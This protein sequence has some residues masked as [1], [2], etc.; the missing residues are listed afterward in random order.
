MVL[1]AP[2]ELVADDVPRPD[3]LAAGARPRDPQRHLRHGLQDLQRRD[4]GQL[5]AHHGPRDGRRGRRRR[6][7]RR[8]PRAATRVIVDPELY[9]GACFHCRI[10]QTHLCPNG[11]LIGR[12]TNGGFA[13]YVA[14][15]ASHVFR[16]ARLDRQPRPRR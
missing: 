15:P 2:R 8:A 7:A 5:S 13:E 3:R 6:R 12:D 10:G 14:A 4:S 16:A 1:R 9:C 11:M